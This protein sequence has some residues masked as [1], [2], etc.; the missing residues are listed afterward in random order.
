MKFF[1]DRTKFYGFT[2]LSGKVKFPI[3]TLMLMFMLYLYPY[4]CFAFQS[5]IDSQNDLAD[6]KLAHPGGQIYRN[7]TQAS[8]PCD[9]IRFET[10]FVV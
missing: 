7:N 4:V 1:K 8:W 10:T 3:I 9:E 2:F 5:L 6:H